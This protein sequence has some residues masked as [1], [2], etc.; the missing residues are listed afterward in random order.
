MSF[1]LLLLNLLRFVPLFSR[2]IVH[3]GRSTKRTRDAAQ[4]FILVAR[5]LEGSSF[6]YASVG[7]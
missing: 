6:G 1:L 5:G 7:V 4:Q 3:R 2:E